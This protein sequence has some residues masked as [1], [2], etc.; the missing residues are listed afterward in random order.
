VGVVARCGASAVRV[1]MKRAFRRYD[2]KHVD[3]R[4]APH[5]TARNDKGRRGRGKGRG[6]GRREEADS[7][8]RLWWSTVR[9]V[10]TCPAVRAG[11]QSTHFPATHTTHI[12]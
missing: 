10:K 6:S 4:R 1:T 8:S 3:V 2:N 7:D 5:R 12:I 9:G 11:E